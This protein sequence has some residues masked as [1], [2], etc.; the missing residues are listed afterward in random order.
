VTAIDIRV[1]EPKWFMRLPNVED[2]LTQAADL[3]EADGEASVLLASDPAVRA[4]NFRFRDKDRATNVLSFPAPPDSQ[5][6][7][8]DVVIA[9]GVCERE[10]KAQHK[11]LADHVRHLLVHGLLHLMG[12]D[13]EEAGEAQAMETLER[14][15]LARIGVPDPYHAGKDHS[16]AGR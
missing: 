4:L 10:A 15:L 12:H 1:D 16:R 14:D 13:H 7:L 9:L 2:L 8:G 6:H 11:P 5:G 3:V